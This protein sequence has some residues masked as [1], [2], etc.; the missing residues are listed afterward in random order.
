MLLKRGCDH[1]PDN[2]VAFQ[3]RDGCQLPCPLELCPDGQS[4]HR[5]AT[6][7]DKF[8]SDLVG[9][10]INCIRKSSV[11]GFERQGGHGFDVTGRMGAGCSSGQVLLNS[12][13]SRNPA[14]G[15]LDAP[16]VV[17]RIGRQ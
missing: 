11:R 13:E 16:E 1:V 14:K 12:I 4:T 5:V 6:N 3:K 2:T 9:L 7:F 17:S 8:T 15:V 10:L